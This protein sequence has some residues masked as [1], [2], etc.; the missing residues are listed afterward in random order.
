MVSYIYFLVS[1]SVSTSEN[2]YYTYFT[3]IAKFSVDLISF[4]W[5]FCNISNVSTD[6]LIFASYF[7]YCYLYHIWSGQIKQWR[8]TTTSV[9]TS[10]H[11]WYDQIKQF[12]SVLFHLIV[13][14]Y[15]MCA[16]QLKQYLYV[17][18]YSL[19]VLSLPYVGVIIKAASLRPITACLFP[20]YHM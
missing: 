12:L 3:L 16:G 4:L 5:L 2:C 1:V 7:S 9:D 20:L 11:V 14:H 18:N 6:G 10:I 15:H 17:H 19:F 8:N 13:L